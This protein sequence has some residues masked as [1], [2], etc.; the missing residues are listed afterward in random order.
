[1]IQLKN[2]VWVNTDHVI[3]IEASGPVIN[4][5]LTDDKKVQMDNE[6]DH[7][8]KKH[9]EELAMQINFALRGESR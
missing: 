8:A 5:F 6:T 7:H 9:R 4:V 2:K 3:L 1:M